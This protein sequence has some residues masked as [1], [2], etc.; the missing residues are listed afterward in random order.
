MEYQK[1]TPEEKRA[2][3]DKYI[4]HRNENPAKIRVNGRSCLLDVMN[5]THNMQQLVSC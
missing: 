2:A 1:L 3:V 5:V 4:T